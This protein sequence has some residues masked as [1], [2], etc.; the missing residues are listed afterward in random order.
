MEKLLYLSPNNFGP[1]CQSFT[2]F[3][4]PQTFSSQSNFWAISSGV[5]LNLGQQNPLVSQILWKAA[6]ACMY[7]VQGE[8][9]PLPLPVPLWLD[10][11]RSVLPRPSAAQ[12][13][14]A[15]SPQHGCAWCQPSFLPSRQKQAGRLVL[16]AGPASCMRCSGMKRTC[17]PSPPPRNLPW[18]GEKC[19]V[20]LPPSCRE[21]K[22]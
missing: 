21:G 4:T 10:T 19:V 22:V 13:H 3:S 1:V 2:G 20:V 15:G 5:W 9:F 17:A 18:L 7:L 8:G 14:G 6:N 12:P 16:R 11:G